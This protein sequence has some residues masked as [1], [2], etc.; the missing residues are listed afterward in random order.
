MDIK[1]KALRK[2]LTLV[3]KPAKS[4]SLAEEEPAVDPHTLFLYLEE[5]RAHTKILKARSLSKKKSRKARNAAA[6]EYSHMKVLIKVGQESND[7][8]LKS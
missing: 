3:L 2:A 6:L 7:I 5:I 1:S 4:V 8:M